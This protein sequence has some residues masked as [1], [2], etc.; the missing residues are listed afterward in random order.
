MR[1]ANASTSSGGE[2][3]PVSPSRTTSGEPSTA[4]A[5]AGVPSA[6]VSSST[7]GRP[8]QREESTKASLARMYGATLPT[9]PRKTM[10]SATPRSAACCLRS[11]SSGPDA[12]ADE[13]GL[14]VLRDHLREGRDRISVA[15]WCTKRPM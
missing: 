6:S 14:G 12:G 2:S 13:L 4:V 3:Q 5:I 11:S 1:A 8:S 15:F 10:R 7:T 9:A